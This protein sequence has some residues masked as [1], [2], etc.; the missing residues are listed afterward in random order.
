MSVFGRAD[1]GTPELPAGGGRQGHGLL[2]QAKAT[3]FVAVGVYLRQKERHAGRGRILDIPSIAARHVGRPLHA[4][5][6][7]ESELMVLDHRAVR[8]FRVPAGGGL[9]A[10]A[11]PRLE[12]RDQAALRPSRSRGCCFSADRR[13]R[14]RAPFPSRV[15]NRQCSHPHVGGVEESS[16]PSMDA[17]RRPHRRP[18]SRSSEPLSNVK[19]FGSRPAGMRRAGHHACR[20]PDPW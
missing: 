13:C 18:L 3:G 10:F 11:H 9:L 15:A 19:I 12:C 16:V 17:W 8:E 2:G 4:W 7:G 20:S 14:L 5:D 6:G 1:G